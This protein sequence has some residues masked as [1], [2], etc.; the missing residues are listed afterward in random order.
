MTEAELLGA[1]QAIWGN[2]ISL[3]AILITVLSGF[4]II[5]YSAGKE[6]SKRQ[7][8]IICTLYI[9]LSIFLLASAVSFIGAA[10]ELD[11]I[12]IAMTTQR[13]IIPRGYL[14]YSVAAFMVFCHLASLFFMWDA[15][16]SNDG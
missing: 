3:L 7:V 16:K 6:L 1:S 8:R 15:R 9:G 11:R 10:S 4:L 2:A 12:S 14:A 5:A 13:E